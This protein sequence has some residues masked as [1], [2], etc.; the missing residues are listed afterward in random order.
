MR[1]LALLAG[2]N[3]IACAAKSKPQGNPFVKEPAPPFIL[4]QEPEFE[5]YTQAFAST[6]QVD[7][8]KIATRFGNVL[9][10]V[11]LCEITMGK[12]VDQR[13]I[14]IEPDYWRNATILEREQLIWHELGHCAL[15]LIHNETLIKKGEWQFPESIMF[16][17]VFGHLR[18]YEINHAYYIERLKYEANNR[19]EYGWEPNSN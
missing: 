18:F 4:T 9:P 15:L 14:T 13:R 16:P 5:V 11:G 12:G 3:L 10:N 17:N 1:V 2:I 7:V 6:F 19:Q 8:S